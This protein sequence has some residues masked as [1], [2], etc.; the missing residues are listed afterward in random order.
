MLINS[1]PSVPDGFVLR[2]LVELTLTS[3]RGSVSLIVTPADLESS[4]VYATTRVF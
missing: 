2:G 3:K 1:T 4:H